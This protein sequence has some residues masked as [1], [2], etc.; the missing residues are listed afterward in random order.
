MNIS[1]TVILGVAASDAHVVA[2][3]LIERLLSDRGFNVVNLGACTTID[4]FCQAYAENRSAL[5]I[6]IG[7]LNGHAVNDVTGLTLAKRQYKVDCPVIMG[8][9]LS[10][11]SQKDSSAIEALHQLG[12]DM[13][14][15]EPLE[16][17]D[18]LETLAANAAEAA[19]AAEASQ[20]ARI[21]RNA[22][23]VGY[24]VA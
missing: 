7:S 16:L 19:E 12:V 20:T 4:E 3:K 22:G 9:N 10:V 6:V 14:L 24:V 13:I 17:V 21:A 23:K 15:D 11:G 2:N 5:A 8:G 1:K 18:A